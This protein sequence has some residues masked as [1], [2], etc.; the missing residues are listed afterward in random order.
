M[1]GVSL[2]RLPTVALN[3]LGVGGGPVAKLGGQLTQLGHIQLSHAYAQ[4]HTGRRSAGASLG[5][6][7]SQ[8]D[9]INRSK[10][11]WT[12]TFE[13]SGFQTEVRSVTTAW[14]AGN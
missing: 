4:P 9:P 6:A 3:V 2:N 10:P 13:Q 14:F 5:D 12:V 8:S 7:G 11:L 1:V